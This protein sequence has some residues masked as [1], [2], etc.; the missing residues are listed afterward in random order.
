MLN[1][2]PLRAVITSPIRRISP[3]INLLTRPEFDG[4]HPAAIFLDVVMRYLTDT[5][6][7]I[8]LPQGPALGRMIDFINIGLLLLIAFGLAR[9]TWDLLPTPAVDAVPPPS[10]PVTTRMPAAGNAA[11]GN[12]A[13]LH[14]FGQ[15]QTAPANLSAAPETQL[16]LTL[17]GVLADDE[18]T[19]ARAIIS[20]PDGSENAYAIGAALPGNATLKQIH[21][22]RVVLLSAGRFET[23]RLPKD[24]ALF[25]GSAG[26]S[27]SFNEAD[28]IPDPQQFVDDYPEQMS[29]AEAAAA[30][31]QERAATLM[32]DPVALEQL[33][34]AEP[35]MQDGKIE[36]YRLGPGYDTR[37]LRRFGLQQGDT[38]TAI[39][40]VGLANPAETYSAL[41]D[42]AELDEV[43]LTVKR[44]G[45]EQQITVPT[46]E[47]MDA[48]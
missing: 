36:G 20:A 38:V 26:S 11:L 25:G 33:N 4:A 14:L 7:L 44:N 24:D 2:F 34:Q 42:I 48:Q 10:A 8:R 13:S 37:M 43:T 9:F 17:H 15:A 21:A 39:N 12:L 40:G 30:L 22:D 19:D 29:D 23:L 3:L 32:D 16:A 28:M 45:R 47:L 31:E 27:P 6:T 46:S 41:G 35:V 5:L 1:S 18:D